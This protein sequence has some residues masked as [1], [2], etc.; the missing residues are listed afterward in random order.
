MCLRGHADRGHHEASR[1][2]RTAGHP[3]RACRGDPPRDA[4]AP[5]L[6]RLPR[7]QHR[8]HRGEGGRRQ[9]HHLSPLAHQERSGARGPRVGRRVDAGARHR[10]PSRRLAGDRARVPGARFFGPRSELVSHLRGRVRGS[11]ARRHRRRGA[12][13]ERRSHRGHLAPRH[14]PRRD[15]RGHGSQALHGS[16]RRPVAPQALLQQ[17]ARRR[18]VHVTPHRSLAPRRA[19]HL[20]AQRLPTQRL[21]AQRAPGNGRPSGRGRK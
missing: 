3:R 6:R 20:P 21:P 15:L 5:R 2:E 1:F 13:S 16:V 8:R 12:L 18:G 11:R 10:H 14:R 19:Q 9:D 4:R 17:R 7:P